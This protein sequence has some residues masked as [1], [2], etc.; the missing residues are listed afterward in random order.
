MGKLTLVATPE[1]GSTRLLSLLTLFCDGQETRTIETGAQ[2]HVIDILSGKCSFTI[3]VAGKRP[4]CYEGVGGR[5]DIFSGKPEW[6]YVP[7]NRRYE[8]RCF[9]PLTAVIYAAPTEEEAPPAHVKADAVLQI[10]AGTSDW[11]REVFIGMGAD[12]AATRMMVGE[13][14][15]PPGNWSG[16]PPHRHAFDSPPH[17]IPL[18]ELF[19]FQ[20]QPQS[21]FVIAGTYQDPYRKDQTAQLA[22][23]RHGQAFDAFDGFHFIAPCP[24]HRVRYTWALGGRRKG[25]GKWTNDPELA[26]LSEK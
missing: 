2:E 11:R 21:G 16:F 17:E 7:R 15:S 26:W 8:V 13:T 3:S 5:S 9:E 14:E 10:T 25:F 1:A 12:G 6:V 23:Y 19:F 20:I 22:I 18:E 24:G 4:V